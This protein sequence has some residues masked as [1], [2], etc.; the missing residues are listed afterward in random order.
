MQYQVRD[1]E[2]VIEFDG[3]VLATATSKA[4]G[5]SRWIELTLYKTVAGTYVL[6]GTGRSIVSNEVDRH[7]VQLAETPDGVID[8]LHLRN[9]MGARYIPHTSQRL[10]KDAGERD[11][12]IRVAFHLTHVA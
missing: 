12:G 1:G 4:R 5:K 10:L 3:D 2:R 7:W 9:D 11:D 8:R 6:H